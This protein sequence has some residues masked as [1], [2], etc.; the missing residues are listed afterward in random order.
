MFFSIWSILK[1][2]I[3]MNR[4]L[5]LLLGL[6]LGLAGQAQEHECG[7]TLQSVYDRYE[8]QPE[9]LKALKLESEAFNQRLKDKHTVNYSNAKLAADSL[10]KVVRYIPVVF[11]VLHDERNY[12]LSVGQIESQIRILNE[13]FRRLNSTAANTPEPFKYTSDS[14]LLTFNADNVSDLAGVEKYLVLQAG[15]TDLE[16]FEFNIPSGDKLVIY[17]INDDFQVAPIVEP[18]NGESISYVSVDITSLTT[19][20]EVRD[21]VQLAID[22]NFASNVTTSIDTTTTEPSLTIKNIRNGHAVAELSNIPAANLAMFELEAGR[23]IAADARIEFRLAKIDPDG[24]P[25]TGI[26]RI[27]SDR[28]NMANASEEPGAVT[29]NSWRNNMKTVDQWDAT[30]Y[31]NIWTVHSIPSTASGTILGFAQFP[32][33]LAINPETDGVVLADPYVGD[34]GTATTLGRTLTHEAGHWLNL[35]HIWGDDD[36]RSNGTQIMDNDIQDG[37]IT[38]LSGGSDEVYDT[39]NQGNR[40]PN[41]CPTFVEEGE[42]GTLHGDMFMNYMDYSTDE[43][44]SLFTFGQ[45]E[46]MRAAMEDYRSVIWSEEN[47]MASGISESFDAS[48]L[49][50]AVD[51][52]LSR[53]FVCEGSEIEF[54]NLSTN[55]DA[56]SSYVWSFPGS[57]LPN[58]T[59]K[60]ATVEFTE[61]GAYSVQL[62]VTN[63]NG[64]TTKVNNEVIYVAASTA[65]IITPLYANFTYYSSING[66]NNIVTG[67]SADG[68]GGWKHTLHGSP[69]DNAD[70]ALRVAS[71]KNDEKE[72]QTLMFKTLNTND[73]GDD[74]TLSF[75]Y[76]YAKRQPDAD[77]RFIISYRAS[78]SDNATWKVLYQNSTNPAVGNDVE[79]EGMVTNGG[80]IQYLDFIPTDDDWKTVGVVLPGS[81]KGK[82]ELYLR[83]EYFGRHGNYFYLDNFNLSGAPLGREDIVFENSI[84]VLPNPNNGQGSVQFE[85]DNSSDVSIEIVDI[86]GKTYGSLTSEFGEGKNKVQIESIA[87]Q[88]SNGVYFAK[89]TKNNRVYT[90]KFV[91]SK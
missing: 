87:G 12:N 5:F 75:D 44:M 38:I 53:R 27:Y 89:V 32:N 17:F 61:P 88:I 91:V 64:T 52:M 33:Q 85:L 24:N 71:Y 35:I 31:F 8:G 74:A 3:T 50:P 59:T 28:S 13:D 82:D 14:T 67:L 81:F 69:G 77:D 39:P 1:K 40:T 7:S 76:A 65:E 90:Q 57:S 68:V 2:T 80:Q 66:P 25:T 55:I 22:D 54:L 86:I 21:A 16:D 20:E 48:T 10:D 84:G 41:N 29:Y 26:N 72:V 51:F 78:C 4:S 19:T 42:L 62:E 45:V 63:A 79:T 49:K 30:K 9:V 70:G 73:L 36:V 23:Y 56:S 83:I 47:L 18:T 6:S 43:C 37:D 58:I 46:R 11:H 15:P 34:E 60:D